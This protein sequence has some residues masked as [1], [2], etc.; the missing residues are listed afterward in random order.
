MRSLSK[1]KKYKAA[2]IEVFVENFPELYIKMKNSEHGI[3][4]F[5]PSKYHLE[6]DVW[7]HTMMVLGHAQTELGSVAALLHDIGKPFTR[8]VK[9][10][11]RTIF[12]CHEGFGFFMLN[13]ILPVFDL[14]PEEETI[15]KT[16]VA[17]HGSFR[18]GDL[19]E[20]IEYTYGLDEDT[21]TVLVDLLNSDSN[22]RINFDS[23]I[24]SHDIEDV[25]Y[26][27]YREFFVSHMNDENSRKTKTVTFLIG[28][29]GSGK[30]TY[31]SENDLGKVL[32]RDDIIEMH[33]KGKTYEDKYAFFEKS[34]NK[35]ELNVLFDKKVI[36]LYSNKDDVVVDMT[37][38]RESLRNKLLKKFRKRGFKAKA[39]VFST[40]INECINRNT[41]RKG[42]VIDEYV[43]KNNASHFKFPLFGKEYFDEITVI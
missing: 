26:S 34:R 8:I 11:T 22:G 12:S 15:I 9:D 24:W 42:K 29:P 36:E 25:L 31:L 2:L 3:D 28:L 7:T 1:L 13:D 10:E 16:V 33:G 17:L 18:S 37:N 19:N 4:K 43:I 5:K 21:I 35:Q 23:G 39:V 20:F 40:S 27:G 14:S 41:Q 30:S 32:S 6:G 38:I